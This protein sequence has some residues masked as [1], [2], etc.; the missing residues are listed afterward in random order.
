MKQDPLWC[1]PP[2]FFDKWKRS[3]RGKNSRS[4]ADFTF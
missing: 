2:D 4:N 3:G 1:S